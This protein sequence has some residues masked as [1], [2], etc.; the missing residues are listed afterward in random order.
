MPERLL[1]RMDE[2]SSK[3]DTLTV[4]VRNTRGQ[5]F[6]LARL[7]R[8]TRRFGVYLAVVVVAVVAVAFAGW[9]GQRIQSNRDARELRDR[10]VA[11]CTSIDDFA[12]I[13]AA[14][15]NG[16]LD[17]FG[18]A[19]GADRIAA[20]RTAGDTATKAAAENYRRAN[21]FPSDCDLPPAHQDGIPLWLPV[22]TGVVLVGGFALVL[23]NRR[24]DR[25]AKERGEAAQ[26]LGELT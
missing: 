9:N 11:F 12:N 20:I 8:V 4:E 26:R 19:A 5:V 24:R 6:T 17:S 15:G 1:Q 25:D 2:V 18:T 7:S 3:L 21:G 13:G 10:R 14:W 16:V 22:V 23:H